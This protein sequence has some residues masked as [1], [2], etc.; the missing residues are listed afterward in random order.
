MGDS[1]TIAIDVALAPPQYIQE[2]ARLINKRLFERRPNGF[3]FDETHWPHLTLLQQFIRWEDIDDVPS[4]ISRACRGLG[5]V[6]IRVT[7]FNKSS[8]TLHWAVEPAPALQ[9]LHE[10][11]TEILSLWAQEKGG[12]ESFDDRSGEKPRFSDI[13][14]VRHYRQKAGGVNFFPHITLG[15]G[16][17]PTDTE[18]FEF[19]ADSLV[20]FHLGRYCTCRRVLKAWT[21]KNLS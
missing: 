5:P 16:E 9:S 4:A 15:L 21:L 1:K 7:R 8:S 13:E 18:I 14:W 17:P 19:R 20:L 11:I 2:K 6:D 10:K 3:L 12:F